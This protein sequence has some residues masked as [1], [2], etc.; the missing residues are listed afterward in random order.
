MQEIVWQGTPIDTVLEE[1]TKPSGYAELRGQLDEYVIKTGKR[2]RLL[3]GISEL[4]SLIHQF[5]QAIA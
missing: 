2:R 3:L 4:A 1:A 5:Q